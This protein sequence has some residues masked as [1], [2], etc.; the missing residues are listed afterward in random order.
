MSYC[1]R[2]DMIDRFGVERLTQLT[3]RVN[4]PVSTID[5]TVLAT[6]ID[7]AAGLIDGYLKK[8]AELPLTVVPPVL[9]KFNADIALYYLYGD[10]AD[11]DSPVTRTYNDAVSFLK[12]VAKGLVELSDGAE[13]PAVSGDGAIRTAAPVRV[14]TR[15]SLKG[16]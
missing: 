10:N 8:V 7:D 13:V 1:Q 6:A 3:D 11:K 16:F 2:Q 12:D 4:K 14:F 5:E 15:D 9:Q